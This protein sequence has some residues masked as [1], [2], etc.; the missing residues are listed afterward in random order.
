MRGS[1]SD[2]YR[3]RADDLREKAATLRRMLGRLG[4]D[5]RPA[6]A[7]LALNY[8]AMATTFEALATHVARDERPRGHPEPP[9]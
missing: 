3:I 2:G 8:D 6:L 7:A 5:A 1:D 4:P 9:R